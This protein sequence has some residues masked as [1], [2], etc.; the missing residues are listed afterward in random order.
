MRL[1]FRHE[2][3]S[4]EETMQFDRLFVGELQMNEEDRA[5]LNARADGCSTWLYVDGRLAGEQVLVPVRS[6][7]KG[8]WDEWNLQEI[9][10]IIKRDRH[11]LL[12]SLYVYSTTLLPSYQGKGL[13]K[14]LSAYVLGYAR[15]SR[16]LGSICGHAT[17]PG[18]CTIRHELGA[19]F[20][21]THEDWF[22]SGRKAQWYEHKI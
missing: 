6:F 5:E 13:G 2:C 3:P 12:C 17:T 11:R 4:L 14:I 20:G 9:N 8:Q 19:V 7:D 10:E 18:M 1:E 16:I 21:P 22:G 15:G